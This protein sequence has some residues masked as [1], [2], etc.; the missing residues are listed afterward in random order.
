MGSRINY[1]VNGFLYSG[2]PLK[3]EVMLPEV[4]KLRGGGG[5][6]LRAQRE[7]KSPS[8]F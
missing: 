1:E 8:H 7:A 5:E 3:R 4:E 2:K 6:S